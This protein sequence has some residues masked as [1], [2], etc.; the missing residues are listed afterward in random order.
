[1]ECWKYFHV[2]DYPLHSA[3]LPAVPTANT[4]AAK[5]EKQLQIQG[6]KPSTQNAFVYQAPQLWNSA[7]KVFREEP[8][9]VEAKR[10]L[11]AHVWTYPR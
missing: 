8:D 6:T 10:W 1:M 4:R 7:P 2:P 5:N 3:L 9:M 11:G